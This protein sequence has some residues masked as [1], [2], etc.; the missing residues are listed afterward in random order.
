MKAIDSQ[1]SRRKAE[2]TRMRLATATMEAN[3]DQRLCEEV[4]KYPRL[5][6]CSMKEHRREIVAP[7][8]Q[9]RFCNLAQSAC[10]EHLCTRLM[11]HTL[12]FMIL[13]VFGESESSWI[14][15]KIC[16]LKMNEGLNGFL[17]T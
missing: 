16:V 17:S 4:R 9:E 10:V 8:D 3:I 15:S 2:Q 14:S 12:V 7:L 5:Y 11:K 13:A 6:D 1:D